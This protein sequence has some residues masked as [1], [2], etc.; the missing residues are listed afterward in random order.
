M[1]LASAITPEKSEATLEFDLKQKKKSCRISYFHLGMG[2]ANMWKMKK[3]VMKA[4]TRMRFQCNSELEKKEPSEKLGV[5][6]MG[7]VSRNL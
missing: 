6:Q 1:K 2:R 5:I 4:N 7:H 3:E